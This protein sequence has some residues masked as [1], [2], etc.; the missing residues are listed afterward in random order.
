VLLIGAH[1]LTVP[2]FS[3]ESKKLTMNATDY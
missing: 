1:A 2:P 3:L